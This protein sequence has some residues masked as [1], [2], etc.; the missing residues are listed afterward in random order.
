MITL[1]YGRKLQHV[2]TQPGGRALKRWFNACENA[3]YSA[4]VYSGGAQFRKTILKVSPS[5]FVQLESVSLISSSSC[6]SA[7]LLVL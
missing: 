1:K 5:L 3:R 6:S 2:F 7:F 4:L